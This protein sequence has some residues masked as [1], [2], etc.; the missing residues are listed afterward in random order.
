MSVDASTGAEVPPDRRAGRGM[1]VIRPTRLLMWRGPG[2]RE[3]SAVVPRA[4]G[5]IESIGEGVERCWR[6]RRV[7]M[8]LCAPCAGCA[9]C[10]GG[11]PDHCLSPRRLDVVSEGARAAEAVHAPVS[12]LAVL[13]AQVDDDAGVF[14]W[15]VARVVH[16]AARLHLEGK[17]YVTVLGDNALGLLAAQ[18]MSA[19]NAS[20]RCLGRRA[21]FYSLCEKWG[22]KHRHLDEVGRRQDQDVVVECS[23]EATSLATATA[24]VRVLGKIALL[25][26]WSPEDATSASGAIEAIIRRELAVIGVSGGRLA[27]GVA[28]L[29]GG[30]VETA[31][32]VT[33]R[34]RGADVR[35]A[36]RAALD[37]EHL[38]VLVDL[39]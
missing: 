17:P 27:D 15:D 22:V 16:A 30:G 32:L 10:C 29:A 2:A 4:V 5:V 25:R 28:A 36:I 7:A 21:R 26:A 9:S 34:F 19:R 39:A 3:A 33:R 24:L 18:V 35:Q 23:G 1:A 14:A 8:P 38:A 37:D 20:V 13:P 12:A 11:I 31:S 6:G